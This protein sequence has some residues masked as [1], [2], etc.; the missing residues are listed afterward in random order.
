MTAHKSLLS[1]LLFLLCISNSAN[2]Q[3]KLSEPKVDE[4]ESA[5][6]SSDIDLPTSSRLRKKKNPGISPAKKPTASTSNDESD[7]SPTTVDEDSSNAES[8]SM[9]P[10]RATSE[11]ASAAKDP[12]NSPRTSAGKGVANHSVDSWSLIAQD[13]EPTEFFSSAA[14]R[15]IAITEDAT[16]N[17]VCHVGASCWAVGERG[18]VVRSNDHGQTWTTAITPVDCSL[19]S[20]CFLTNRMG[21]IAGYRVISGTS[22][23]SAVLFQTRDGGESWTDLAATPQISGSDAMTTSTLPGI[24]HVRFFGLDEAMAVTL[25]VH[26]RGGAGIF[27]SDDGGQSWTSLATDQAGSSWNTGGFLSMAEGVVV[28]QHQS[29]AAVVS[30][31]AVVINPSQP[32]LRQMRGVSLNADGSGWIVGDNATIFTTQN[33]G[34]TWEPPATELPKSTSELSDLC[35]VAHHGELVLLGGHPGACVFRSTTNGQQWDTVQI[36]A[37][38]RITKLRFAS[39]GIVLAVGSFGQILRS[40]DDGQI[41]NAVRSSNFRS[42]VLNLV[43]NADR[44]SWQLL[45]ATAAEQGVRSVTVQMSQQLRTSDQSSAVNTSEKSRLAVTQLAGNEAVA[46]WMFPRTR[47]EH[48]RSV[49]QLISEWE[50]QTD[51]EVRRLLPLRLARELR[52]WRPAVVVIESM[53]DD[54]AVSGIFADALVRAIEIA[55]HDE[56]ADSEADPDL[57]AGAESLNALGLPPWSVQRI[58]R[59]VPSDRQSSPSYDDNDLLP[60]LGTTNGL[61]C[62]AALRVITGDA[63]N[64]SGVRV[65]SCY[66]VVMDRNDTVGITNLLQGLD[67]TSLKGARRAVQHRSGDQLKQLQQVLDKSRIEGSA[68]QGHARLVRA[69]ESLTAELQNVGVD[70]PPALA[71]KQLKDLGDLNL[72]QNNMEGFIAVQ[73]EIIR[74]YPQTEDGRL[75]AEMLFLFYSSEETR[76]YRTRSKSGSPFGASVATAS[77]DSP[78]VSTPTTRQASNPN[79]N[80]S[81]AVNGSGSINGGESGVDAPAAATLITPESR[82]PQTPGFVPPGQGQDPVAALQQRWDSHAATA[83]RILSARD[84]SQVTTRQMDPAVLLRYAVNQRQT[85]ATGEQSNA[86]A[87]LSQRPDEFGLFAKSEMQLRAAATSP[88]PLFNLPRQ[89]ERPFLDGRL[90]DSIWENA[91]EIS[92]RSD[93]ASGRRRSDSTNADS[94]ASIGQGDDNVRSFSMLAWDEQFLFISARL[95]K[96]PSKSKVVELAAARSHDA[97]HGDKDRFEIELDTDRDYVTSFQLTVD[98]SGQTSDRCW[99]LTR[100]NPQWYVAVDS[101][102]TAW[103]IEAAIPFSE[104]ISRPAKAGDIWTVRMRR[105]LPGVLE[106]SSMSAESVANSGKTGI[107]RFIRPKVTTESRMRKPKP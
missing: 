37:T 16:L 31:Q 49:S 92:L 67:S 5:A 101:D 35:T 57:I 15:T 44:A 28:G 38:G 78:A 48:H 80:D 72:Q 102:E 17:D 14:P 61:L 104:L 13:P 100:W 87:E 30:D 2:A 50:R 59:R 90:T 96:A 9:V 98:E 64:R 53:S 86:L 3:L 52:N 33:S 43:T 82:S 47:P 63:R 6:E 7:S 40:E 54:D 1:L 68:L 70:L 106:H 11:A 65:R 34:V 94:D 27:R 71:A 29:Y 56:H 51:G 83:F 22:Q 26:Q 24:L 93:S 76:Y 19:Q 20:V 66:E 89:T 55:D 103:R 8:E 99:M 77:A 4:E 97:K 32:T 73:Q 23:L 69:E 21:W 105:V 88:L 12:E 74:R 39:E 42:G 60:A 85:D 18:V 46:D 84:A 58:I 41:W 81:D 10:S 79:V 62:D 91:P 45:A 36:P 107:V 95:E 25:P 75:A